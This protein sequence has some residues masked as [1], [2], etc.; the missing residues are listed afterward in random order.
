MNDFH[1]SYFCGRNLDRTR[2]ANQSLI[3]REISLFF[4]LI[5]YGKIFCQLSREQDLVCHKH[6]PR[7]SLQTISF[8]P[9]WKISSFI[10]NM[11][12][13]AE[14]WGELWSNQG[15]VVVCVFFQPGLLFAW[16]WQ[17]WVSLVSRL[18]LNILTICLIYNLHIHMT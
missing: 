2:F 10:L 12:T 11:G 16:D 14:L 5:F 13:I 4:L 15:M 8:L 18:Q 1:I 9:K 7:G 3:I 17:G 6:S